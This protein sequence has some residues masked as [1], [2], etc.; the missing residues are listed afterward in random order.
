MNNVRILVVDDEKIAGRNLQHILKKEG[1]EVEVA[2]GGMEA[3]KLLEQAE[4]REFNLVLTDLKMPKVDG[5]D[6]L[7]K[8]LSISPDTQV[9]MITGYATMDSAISALKA[10]AYHYISK[11]YKLDEVRRVVNE[12]LEK[13]ELRRENRQLKEKLAKIQGNCAII[14]DDPLMRSLLKTARHIAQS[15]VSVLITG[16]SGTGKELMAQY[17]HENSFRAVNPFVAVNCGVFTE[18]LLGNE[19]FGHEKGA[20]TG[21]DNRTTGLFEAAR[22]GSLFLDEIT[23]M[24]PAMQVKLLRAIQ[25]KEIMPLGSTKAV[26]IDVRFIAASNRDILEMVREGSFRQDLYFRINVMNLHLPPL[27]VRRKDIPLLVRH[28]VDKYSA[29]M[30]KKVKGVALEGMQKLQAYDYPG[31]IRELENII[32]RA[33]VLTRGDVILE[34]HLPEMAVQ[35]FRSHSGG[36]ASLEEQERNYIEF[37]L[38]QTGGN[39]TKAADIL[40]IDRVSLWRKLKKISDE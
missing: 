1:Y 39:R 29:R 19:L 24:S 23:A 14:T 17:I 37:V 8:T 16:E 18:E 9:I 34:E 2:G 3:I 22:G 30:D 21:A 26:K 31:N 36:L 38:E 12:A 40:G 20:Y 25:E 6:V 5:M 27:S 10:G 28:F 35:T 13:Q 11:P 15:E 4:G 33:V 7:A 32:E